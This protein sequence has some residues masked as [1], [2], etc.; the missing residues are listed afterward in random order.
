MCAIGRRR[1]RSCGAG[2]WVGRS[3]LRL[4]AAGE[5]RDLAVGLEDRELDLAEPADALL[6]GLYVDVVERHPLVLQRIHLRLPGLCADEWDAREERAGAAEPERQPGEHDRQD[7]ER[8]HRE[9][10]R[11]DGVV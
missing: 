1:G 6:P 11:R 9:D 5:E 4:T 10:R 8:R 2:L 7:R 3:F